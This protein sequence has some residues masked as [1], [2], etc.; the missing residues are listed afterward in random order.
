MH[1]EGDVV[2]KL[3]LST[4]RPIANSRIDISDV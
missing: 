1:I 3:L 4:T 2:V